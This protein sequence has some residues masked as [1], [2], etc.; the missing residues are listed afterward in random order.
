MKSLQPALTLALLAGLAAPASAV[1]DTATPGA[2]RWEI[3]FDA[4]GGRATGGWQVAA[5]D[6]DFN[7]GWGDSLQLTLGLPR[8]TVRESGHESKSGWGNATAGVKWRLID[9][10]DGPV[11]LAL[12]PQYTWNAFPSSVER[13]VAAPGRQVL[14]PLVA[15]ADLGGVELSASAARR[16]VE[17]G[18]AERVLGLRLIGP[19]ARNVDCLAEA[20]Q[21]AVPLARQM[22]LNLGTEWT[23]HEHCMLK[24]YVGR[25][26]GTRRPGRQNLLLRVGLQIVL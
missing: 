9:K 23:F 22:L 10:Q 8:L 3:N 6:A 25:D 1:E 4:A 26:V 14:V 18:P 16:L 21:T 15:S 12:F 19:C 17:R 5:P 13:G 2:G 20:E 24:T 7:Y 11:S